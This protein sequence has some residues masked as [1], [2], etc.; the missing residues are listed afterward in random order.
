MAELLTEGYMSSEESDMEGDTLVYVVRTIPWVSDQL[1]KRRAKL[2][3]IYMKGQ[4]TRFQQR[5]V[6]RVRMKGVPS[7]LPKPTEKKN[8]QMFH[9]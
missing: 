5:T 4:S 8:I 9:L 2:D 3:K 1:R 7:T 6:K